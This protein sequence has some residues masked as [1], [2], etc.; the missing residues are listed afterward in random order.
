MVNVVAEVCAFVNRAVDQW[1]TV[2]ELQEQ[3]YAV[4]GFRPSSEDSATRSG[5]RI[6]LKY[7]KRGKLN[8]SL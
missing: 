7:W 6:F 2:K 1:R 4:G 5:W 3:W 8:T